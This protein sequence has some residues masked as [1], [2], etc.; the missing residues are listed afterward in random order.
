MPG[1]I[2]LAAASAEQSA[3]LAL[4]PRPVLF[5]CTRLAW[6]GRFIF[7]TSENSMIL[8]KRGIY[9][10]AYRFRV[11]LELEYCPR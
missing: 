7:M 8:C 11:C 3:T 9:L 10:R 6:K 2:P 5:T 4:G 1:L